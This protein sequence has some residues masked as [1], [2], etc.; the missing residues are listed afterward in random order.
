L[1]HFNQS[2][3]LQHIGLLFALSYQGG[4]AWKFTNWSSFLPFWI[5]TFHIRWGE[6]N[7]ISNWS[8]YLPYE[9]HHLS[10]HMK[11][12]WGFSTIE[13]LENVETWESF[14]KVKFY[15]LEF[16]RWWSQKGLCYL[17]CKWDCCLQKAHEWASFNKWMIE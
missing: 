3:P 6:C 14:W 13:F 9:I 17:K 11:N 5:I 2:M 7:E 1:S 12:A 10:H 15:P 8:T 4:N 16:W